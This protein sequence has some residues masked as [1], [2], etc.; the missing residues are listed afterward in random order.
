MHR[1]LAWHGVIPCR[2]GEDGSFF[3]KLM[4]ADLQAMQTFLADHRRRMTPF[5]I[6][7][8][9]ENSGS[10]QQQARSIVRP[11]EEAGVTWWLEA[12]YGA[13]ETQGGVKG[14]RICQ[15]P[16]RS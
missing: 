8:E 10:D 4:P 6:V 16:P 15:G 5:D 7:V 13:P 14:T 12:M 2:Q 3:A 9:G 11:L 1:V